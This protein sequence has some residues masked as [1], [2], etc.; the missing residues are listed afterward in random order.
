MPIRN[1]TVPTESAGK[2]YWGKAALYLTG[3][4]VVFVL[5]ATKSIPC[6][7]A[8][9]FHTPCPGC[10][11]TRAVLAIATGNVDGF[12]HANP[13]GLPLAIF[14]FALAIE[15]LRSVLLRGDFGAMDRRVQKIIL[16][17]VLV[18]VVLEIALWIARFF[19][20]F[21]GPVTV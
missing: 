12:L 8:K 19:G 14:A 18:V 11:S 9:M 21:G 20:A 7:F 4:A 17:G 13:F 6:G 1:S 5:L 10:G 15:S 3:Y 16:R 2:R